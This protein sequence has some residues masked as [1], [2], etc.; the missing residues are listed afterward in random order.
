[1]EKINIDVHNNYAKMKYNDSFDQRMFV[2]RYL[3]SEDPSTG[4][5][6][7]LYLKHGNYIVFPR[8]LVDFLQGLDFVVVNDYSIETLQ[9]PIPNSN[10]LGSVLQPESGFNLRRDQVS[11]VEKS[12][13]F[14]RGVIQLPPGSGKTE[15]QS[16][17]LRI[18][19][20]NNDNAKAIVIEPTTELGRSN[21]DRFKK[22]GLDAAFYSDTR[23]MDSAV[24]VAHVSSVLNDLKRDKTLLDKFNIAII[25]EVH[26]QSCSTW[27]KLNLSLKNL[28]Y[29]L[30]FSALAVDEENIYVDR[31]E[32]MDLYEKLIVGSC[33]RVLLHLNSSYFIGEGVLATP[34]LFQLF[35]K[36]PDIPSRK[37]SIGWME[38]YSQAINCLGRNLKIASVLQ[39]FY[40]YGRKSLVLVGTKEQAFDIADLLYGKDIKFGI[41]FGNKES[42]I[43][44]GDTLERVKVD[45]LDL[46]DSG[47]LNLLFATTHL[48]EGV[49]IK[50]LDVC[51]LASGGKKDRRLIQRIGRVLRK[52]K[53]GKYGYI[54]DFFDDGH[55]I[56]TR[57]SDLRLNLY[58]KIVAI[59]EKNLFIKYS[60]EDLKE[61]F[62]ELEGLDSD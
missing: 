27:L 19:F 12:L 51:V 24:V 3:V 8:G 40:Q 1:M 44:D 56:L 11:A 22:Y 35:Y 37:G 39:F 7:N 18:L 54:I 30:G 31:Y 59:P 47:Q 55:Y 42:Y 48:D 13:Y 2:N 41:S 34:V 50:S 29:S 52:T 57:H 46:F 32:M 38:L 10:D 33:G 28:E 4:F 49:D 20:Q 21:C 58:R 25:D 16:A 36:S 45:I 43:Y 6:Q 17:I 5:D 26:H 62:I 14:K 23:N 60:V 53:T 9:A 61:K 15:I